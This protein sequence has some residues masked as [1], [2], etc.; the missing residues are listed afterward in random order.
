MK[1]VKF[2][3]IWINSVNLLMDYINNNLLIL[4]ISVVL[5]I[6]LIFGEVE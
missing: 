4:I 2:G 5:P 6:T 3:E 1:F